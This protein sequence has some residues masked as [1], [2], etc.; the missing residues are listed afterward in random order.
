MSL[1]HIFMTFVNFTTNV[2]ITTV[3]TALNYNIWW[4]IS[5]RVSYIFRRE[6]SF[7]IFSVFMD[8]FLLHLYPYVFSKIDALIVFVYGACIIIKQYKYDRVATQVFW[9]SKL[10]LFRTKVSLPIYMRL[11]CLQPGHFMFGFNEKKSKNFICSEF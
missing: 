4:C 5:Y 6:E 10:R 7:H 8:M 9:W 3:A 1:F 11:K 2:P